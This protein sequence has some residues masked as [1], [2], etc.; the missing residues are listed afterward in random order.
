MVEPDVFRAVAI[1]S[2]QLEPRAFETARQGMTLRR[3]AR[4]QCLFL[5]GQAFDAWPGIVEGLV[6]LCHRTEDGREVTYTGVH[7]GGWFGEGTVLKGEPRRYEVIALRDTTVA[8]LDRAS[9]LWLFENSV[10]FN[11]FLVGQLSERLGQFMGLLENDRLRDPVARVARAL[12]SLLNP[13]LYP[14]AGMRLVLSQEEVGLLAGV[15]RGVANRT[16][17]AL[18]AAGALEVAYGAITVL[19]LEQLRSFG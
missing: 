18:C 15:S 12:A 10:R 3:Y 8:L 5:E 7:A 9:F 14:E 6:K 2:R 11:H 19:D 17:R 1:W 13:V 4:G 16:L